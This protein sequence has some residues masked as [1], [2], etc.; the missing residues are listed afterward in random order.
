MNTRKE[1]SPSS[2]IVILAIFIVGLY[3]ILRGSTT[4]ETKG[5]STTNTVEPK[6][7]LVPRDSVIHKTGVWQIKMTEASTSTSN[8]FSH[9]K[10]Y[11]TNIHKL[12]TSNVV[13]STAVIFFPHNL[14]SFEEGTNKICSD[15]YRVPYRVTTH[16]TC[17]TRDWA[18]VTNVS[19]ALRLTVTAK[20]QRCRQP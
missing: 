13:S 5:T 6:I 20:Q 19:A 10:N 18:T 14:Q 2:T 15:I 3:L 8:I 9:W 16:N 4:L 1:I 7:A 11:T 17:E 12:V